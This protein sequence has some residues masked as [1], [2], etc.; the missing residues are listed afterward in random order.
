MTVNE[1][2]NWIF[3]VIGIAFVVYMMKNKNTIY[4]G[5][6]D[7]KNKIHKIPVYATDSEKEVLRKVEEYMRKNQS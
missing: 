3:V 1:V 4:V 7:R 6:R 2:F 5:V